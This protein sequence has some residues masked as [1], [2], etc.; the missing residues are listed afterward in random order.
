MGQ[1]TIPF[2]CLKCL[3]DYGSMDEPD[4]VEFLG[5]RKRIHLE[6]LNFDRGDRRGARE[7]SGLGS[8]PIPYGTSLY[9]RRETEWCDKYCSQQD[10]RVRVV[11]HTINL[12]FLITDFLCDTLA[13]LPSGP[14]MRQVQKLKK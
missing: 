14:V 1:T 13:G 3:V 4:M 8:L 2:F 9:G 5:R 11:A 6:E 7:G 10:H 12:S